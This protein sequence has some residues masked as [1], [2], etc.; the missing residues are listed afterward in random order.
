[1]KSTPPRSQRLDHWR[2]PSL[3]SPRLVQAMHRVWSCELRVDDL[4]GKAE[5]GGRNDKRGEEW[6]G[7]PSGVA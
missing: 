4:D 5:V 2:A 6:G 3:G 7:A 1:M